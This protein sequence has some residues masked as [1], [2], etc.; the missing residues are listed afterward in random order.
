MR[1]CVHVCVRPFNRSLSSAPREFLHSFHLTLFD[2]LF[3]L[4]VVVSVL[5]ARH[6]GAGM[7]QQLQQVCPTCRGEG[8]V[9]KEKDKCQNCHGNKT[10]QE[11][12]ILEVFIEKGMMN[13]QKLVFTGEADQA[14]G[15]EAGD[16]VLVIK[17]K[18]H[19]R[20]KRRE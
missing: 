4:S 18:E 8:E 14:P 19:P 12:K 2:S 11:K 16:V 15:V 5:C 13:D 17:E 10:V 9:I 20:F 1:V 6:L 7:V 3:V